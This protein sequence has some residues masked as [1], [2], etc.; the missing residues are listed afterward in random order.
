MSNREIVLHKRNQFRTYSIWEQGANWTSGRCPNEEEPTLYYDARC[1]DEVVI[2]LPAGWE[3]YEGQYGDLCVE[4][5]GAG[6]HLVDELIGVTRVGKV[7]LRVPE[8][9]RTLE[10]DVVS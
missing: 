5:P 2:T 1:D 6:A 8:G 10:A 9:A 7:F 3:S 4:V